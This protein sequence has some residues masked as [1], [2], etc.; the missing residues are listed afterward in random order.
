MRLPTI[1]L[2]DIKQEAYIVLPYEITNNLGEEAIK[3]LVLD[4][5]ND[6]MADRLE[7]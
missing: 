1:K 3:D 5:L 7:I 6:F 2:N 4:L